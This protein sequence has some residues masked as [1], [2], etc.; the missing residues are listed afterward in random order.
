MD[1]RWQQIE[2]L[3]HAAR[4]QAPEQRASF[5]ERR[6]GSD[7]E[8]RREIEEL[9]AKDSESEGLVDRPAWD[10]AGDLLQSSLDQPL[11]AGVDLGPYR[12]VNV[13]GIGGM[14]RVYRAQD[15]RLGR[16]VAIK[17]SRNRFTERFEREARAIA[18]L[19]HPN[20]CTLYD[21][22][23]N[24]LVMELVEGPTLA[25]RIKKGPIPLQQALELA[26]QIADALEAAHDAGIV[27]RDLKPGNI[28]IRPDGTVRVLD[29][30]LAKINSRPLAT[31]DGSPS[32]NI[33]AS[34]AGM[35]LGTAAYMAPEQ[36]KGEPVD[37]R[38][39]IWSF[40]AVLY[41][42][43]TGKRLF[44]G[45]SLTEILASVLKEAPDLNPAP[46]AVRRLISSC[47]EK[48]PRKRLRDIGDALRLLPDNT[49]ESA[50]VVGR[51]FRWLPFAVLLSA[52]TIAAAALFYVRQGTAHPPASITFQIIPQGISR[53]EALALSPNGDK[54]AFSGIGFDGVARLWVREFDSLTARSIPE[55]EGIAGFPIWSPDGRYLAFASGGK[56]KKIDASGGTPFTLCD[57]PGEGG[58]LTGDWGQNDVIIF[59]RAGGGIQKV[60]ASGGA[61]SDVTTSGRYPNFLTDA[62]HFVYFQDTGKKGAY[63]GALDFTPAAQPA[64]PILGHPSRAGFVASATPS[65]GYLVYA[66]T[67]GSSAVAGTLMAHPFDPQRMKVSGEPLFV[68]VSGEGS[69][70][71]A[72]P[73]M[74]FAFS[75]NGTIAYSTG[76]TGRYQ[77]V[78]Y[79]RTGKVVGT[80]GDP[81]DIG[82]VAL[83][84][85]ASQAAYHNREGTDDIW[86]FDFARRIS[87][88]LTTGPNRDHQAVW[89]SDGRRIIWGISHGEGKQSLYVKASNGAGEERLVTSGEPDSFNVPDDWSPDGRFL[90]YASGP[91]PSG[92]VDRSNGIGHVV[93]ALPL[94]A[95]GT[96]AGPPQPYLNN[97]LGVGHARFSPNGRFVAYTLGS[98]DSQNVYVSPFPAPQGREE[99]WAVSSG[100]GFQP[101]WRHDGKELFYLS[102]D[103]K[104]MAVDVNTT[105]ENFQSGT[106]KSLFTSR[107]AGG[108]SVAPTHRWDVSPDG[109]R[110]LIVTVLDVTQSPAINIMTNW[111]SALKR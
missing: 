106:P 87:T 45:N 89:S 61:C 67:G 111:E 60:S 52:L 79:D 37:K 29:F 59:S 53:Y 83:S 107:I 81:G 23:P 8:L 20:I 9:L 78:W 93:W 102:V 58:L 64:E 103:G 27:H 51:R 7:D 71:N 96:A 74:M 16:S 25:D 40:G 26:R 18:A 110:F 84:P 38:A 11:A 14:G 4:E 21:V 46:P 104:V 42:M 32:I 95:D 5:L 101:L 73:S 33:A 15:L 68:R 92:A 6:C 41:E 39:D 99:R 105:S 109:Q 88:R 2:E 12:I 28:K 48:D 91:L 50:V 30:G 57:W 69:F 65:R 10:G 56:L 72:T 82:D 63:V 13:L 100:G 77:N 66:Q 55:A 85:D 34:D 70:G 86:L 90:L 1:K 80:G 35:I 24:Y 36:A 17:V 94:Q 49:Q 54:L 47:L 44:T 19:N 31:A 43:V 22:G 98:G 76:G 108:P 3:F 97:A 62:R 75:A